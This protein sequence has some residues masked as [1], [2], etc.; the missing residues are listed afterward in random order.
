MC[1]FEERTFALR[2]KPAAAKHTSVPAVCPWLPVASLGMSRALSP[3]L[4]WNLPA[5]PRW[6][7]LHICLC[8]PWSPVCLVTVTPRVPVLALPVTHQDCNRKGSV[9]LRA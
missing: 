3:S 2:L 7:C 6:P 1:A 4:L 9:L 5:L 8:T